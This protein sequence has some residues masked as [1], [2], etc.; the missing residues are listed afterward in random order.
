MKEKTNKEG[1]VLGKEEVLG[2]SLT[3]EAQ[4]QSTSTLPKDFW[5][6]TLQPSSRRSSTRFNTESS[7][8]LLEELNRNCQAQAK[9]TSEDS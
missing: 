5:H 2:K 1:K 9:R 7:R 6:K 3:G 4:S 8:L